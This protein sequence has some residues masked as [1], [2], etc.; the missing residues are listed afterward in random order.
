[1][2][3]PRPT[4]DQPLVIQKF[5]KNRRH[6][7]IVVSLSKFEGINIVNLRQH[8]TDS[9]GIDRPTPKGVAMAVRRLPDLAKAVNA[10]LAK[11]IELGL[12]GSAEG[13]E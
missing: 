5:W 3:A 2:T 8:Y 13:D 9:T 12:V 11:A 6:E 4:L 10:A 1:M 7:S